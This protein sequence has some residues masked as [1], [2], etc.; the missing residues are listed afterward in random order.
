MCNP[1][2][3]RSPTEVVAE[4]QRI[5]DEILPG[6]YSMVLAG[7]SKSSKET[8]E[9]LGFALVLGIVIAYMILAAQFNSFIHPVTVLI[10]LPFS[11]TGAVLALAYTGNT[12]N[13]FSMIGIVLLMGIVK[14]NSIL[15]VDFT[16]QRRDEGLSVKDAIVSASPTR[17]R[18]IL[19]TTV[20]TIAGAIP[21][22]MSLD[23]SWAGLGASGG[24]ELRA[25]MA[26]AVI[27]GLSLSTLL[28]LFVVPAVYAIFEDLKD[29]LGIGRKSAPAAG[30]ALPDV[31]S[32]A[33]STPAGSSPVSPSSASPI[34]PFERRA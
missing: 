12:L 14:K 29:L 10:A 19:M 30:L 13:M 2:P 5:A 27:G 1:A 22:A 17:L 16:N 28:T 3:G 18:P 23:L 33:S 24:M 6:G 21:A 34:E 8:V 4:A 20:S 32:P 15:L 25:P 9:S 26:I 7:A 11:L 31:P